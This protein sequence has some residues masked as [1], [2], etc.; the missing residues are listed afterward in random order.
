MSNR[1]E[2][3]GLSAIARTAEGRRRV[4]SAM[5]SRLEHIPPELV[6]HV[7]NSTACCP[8]T[9]PLIEAALREGYLSPGV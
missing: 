7:L 5:T 9:Q 8:G 6:V 1:S 2:A 3:L 4:P